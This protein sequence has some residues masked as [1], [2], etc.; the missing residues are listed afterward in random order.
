MVH[1]LFIRSKLWHGAVCCFR[2][3]AHTDYKRH[4]L[5]LSLF[6][7]VYSC[8]NINSF[9]NTQ[10][11]QCNIFFFEPP[12]KRR[13]KKNGRKDSGVPPPAVCVGPKRFYTNHISFLF[14]LRPGTFYYLYMALHKSQTRYK[15]NEYGERTDE[16]NQHCHQQSPHNDTENFV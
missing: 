8:K 6:V 4:Q 2:K 16:G 11:F 1:V 10:L 3:P 14:S 7:Y 12:L 15:V 9:G 13:P 5:H